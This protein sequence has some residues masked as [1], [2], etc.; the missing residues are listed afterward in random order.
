MIRW[1]R[2]KPK[3]SFEQ[4]VVMQDAQKDEDP[5]KLHPLDERK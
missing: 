1:H 4:L 3:E 5:K 2:I